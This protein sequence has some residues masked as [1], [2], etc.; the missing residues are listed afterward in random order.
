MNRRLAVVTCAAALVVGVTAAPVAA[1]PASKGAIITRLSGCFDWDGL[2]TQLCF[3][4]NA[5]S[6][7]AV[8]PSGR[9][10]YTTSIRGTDTREAGPLYPEAS[11]HYRNL[12]V[13][14]YAGDSGTETMTFYNVYER[15]TVGGDAPQTCTSRLVLLI[16][17]GV[18]RVERATQVC[19]TPA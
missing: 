18:V 19:E 15:D 10:V 17:D 14:M 16:M 11:S 4:V 13:R 8:T 6:T 5:V 9:A 7:G 1:E 12:T 3:T 2:G